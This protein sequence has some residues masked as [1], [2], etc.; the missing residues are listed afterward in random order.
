MRRAA[1]TPRNRRNRYRIYRQVRDRLT[2]VGTAPHVNGLGAKILELGLKGVFK[3][4]VMGVLDTRGIATSKGTW[5]VDP[6]D[7]APRR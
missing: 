4:S 6:F 1:Q 3:G 5:I 2:L 7:Y